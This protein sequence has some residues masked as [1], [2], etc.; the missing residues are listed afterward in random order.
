M[1]SIELFAGGGGLALGLERSGLSPIS[2]VEWDSDS[3]ETLRLS[4]IPRLRAETCLLPGDIRD[5]DFSR[6][7]DK[8]DVVSGGPPCQPFSIGGKHRGYEDTRD[9]FPQAARTVK[10]VRPKAFIF[11]NVR[12]LLRKSFARYF[13]YVLL[14]LTYPEIG[15]KPKEDWSDHQ[16]RLERHHTSGKETG[17][18]YQVVFRRVNAAD[19]GVPQH[20]E[21]VVIVGFRSDIQEPWSFPQPTHSGAALLTSKWSTGAYWEEHRIPRSRRPAPPSS[22]RTMLANQESL[23]PAERWI[24]VRDAIKDLPDPRNPAAAAIPNHRFQPGAKIYVGHTGSPED[25]PAKT[26]K[27]G[28]HGVPGGENMIAYSDGSVR[29]FTV[30]ESARLQTFPDDYIFPGSWTESMRQIGNAVPVKLG[31]IVGRSVAKALTTNRRKLSGRN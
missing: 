26:L 27:A 16:Q 14:Q 9:M 31:E 22:L 24:T 25:E 8:V 7:Q 17:L 3:C 2:I 15:K 1:N 11:E 4:L 23:L 20:R 10:E 28:D 6:W 18:R 12:G 30:R 29:Y 19:Y 21:R 13:G 5:F